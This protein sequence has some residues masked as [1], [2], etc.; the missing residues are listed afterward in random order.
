MK[1]KELEW[2]RKVNTINQTYLSSWATTHREIEYKGEKN[3]EK[4]KGH[5]H[6][7]KKEPYIS[8][9]RGGGRRWSIKRSS[10]LAKQTNI[11]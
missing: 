11:T 10:C 6:P 1:K 8:K 4:H 7:S 5:R 9:G 3:E 2:A